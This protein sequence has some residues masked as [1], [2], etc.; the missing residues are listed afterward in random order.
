VLLGYQ[1]PGNI[2]ELENVVARACLLAD[3]DCITPDELPAHIVSE[4]A[5]HAGAAANCD[6]L[7]EQRRR[8]ETDVIRNAIREAGGD[9]KAAAGRLKISV[10]SLYAK[11]SEGA[12]EREVPPAPPR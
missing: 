1:W 12:E 7:Q 4:A 2:R 5:S 8:F 9:R 3:G 6:S 10:S 11:L